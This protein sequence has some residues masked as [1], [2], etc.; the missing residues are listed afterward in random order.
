[1]KRLDAGW[2]ETETAICNLELCHRSSFHSEP[3]TAKRPHAFILYPCLTVRTYLI[4]TRTLK[5]SNNSEWHVLLAA[6]FGCRASRKKCKL[7]AQSMLM[8]KSWG[9][10][11]GG[12]GGSTS[13]V[14]LDLRWCQT[15]ANAEHGALHIV[16]GNVISG[17]AKWKWNP[18]VNLLSGSD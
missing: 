3:T 7:W 14:L 5:T 10:Q 8:H 2:S 18:T 9:R 13:C 11:K 12:F 17:A 1:M 4:R 6:W 16:F 15:D